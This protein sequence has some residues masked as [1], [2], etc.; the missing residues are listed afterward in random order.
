MAA[1]DIEITVHNEEPIFEG[2]TVE[3][4]LSWENPEPDPDQIVTIDWGDGETETVNIEP[5][6]P[7]YEHLFEH[8]Y[9]TDGRYDISFTLFDGS[10]TH[11]VGLTQEI[12]NVAPVI[13]K[14]V[15]TLN[16]NTGIVNLT[17]A[18]DDP[19]EADEFVATIDWGDGNVDEIRHDDP[20]EYSI[21]H[22][23][24]EFHGDTASHRRLIEIIISDNVDE[25]SKE[26]YPQVLYIDSVNGFA[27]STGDVRGTI[28][29]NEN[30]DDNAVSVGSVQGYSFFT[31]DASGTAALSILAPSSVSHTSVLILPRDIKCKKVGSIPFE[32]L[33]KLK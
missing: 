6:P 8:V 13:T 26:L 17:Y 12:L 20:G 32:Q 25:N 15:A 30:V 7:L 24:D 11:I 10:T 23:Y 21:E 33:V 31:K 1:T 4:T 18:F 16:N 9:A 19:S 22:T 14:A 2:D 29:Y 5:D 28:L 3:V 27:I